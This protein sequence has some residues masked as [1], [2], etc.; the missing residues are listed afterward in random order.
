MPRKMS[1]E[2]NLYPGL[3]GS[4]EG[5]QVQGKVPAV[6]K[7]ANVQLKEDAGVIQNYTSMLLICIVCV[8]T[9]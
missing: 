4:S 3:C 5:P 8:A 6:K 9:A 1:P 7:A 2:H